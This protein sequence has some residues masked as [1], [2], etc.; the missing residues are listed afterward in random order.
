VPTGT[1]TGK[2][3]RRKKKLVLR[4]TLVYCSTLNTKPKDENSK[5]HKVYQ[6]FVVVVVIL[7]RHNQWR[8]MMTMRTARNLLVASSSRSSVD[9]GPRASI[10]D[11][12]G[13]TSPFKNDYILYEL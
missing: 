9:L 6:T 7:L 13:V 11:Q 1:N 2:N 8:R 10:H 12:A 4:K 3:T 5:V